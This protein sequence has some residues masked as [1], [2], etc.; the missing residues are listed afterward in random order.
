MEKVWE[1]WLKEGQT[2]VHNVLLANYTSVGLNET[3]LIFVIQLQSYLDRN[4]LFPN[5]NTIAKRMGKEDAELFSVLHS[6]IQKSIIRIQTEKDETGKVSDQYSLEPLYKKLS[7]LLSK[8]QE[9]VK[10][11]ENEIDLLSIFQQEFGRLLTP[12]EIQTISDWLDKDHYKKEII[13]EALREAVLNQKYN[14]RYIDRILLSWE[15]KNIRTPNEIKQES[16]KFS[17]YQAGIPSSSNTEH[18]PLFNWLE[19]DSE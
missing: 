9:H 1:M 11:T 8:E 6:L 16:K 14:L 17:D 10:S 5:I 18:V 3:E 13:L 15:K 4:I 19:P 2:V 12:I 7:M